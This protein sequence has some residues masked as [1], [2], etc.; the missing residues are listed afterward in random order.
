M[1]SVL[2][3][4]G[5][6]RSE[7]SVY[8]TL[9]KLGP[10]TAGKIAKHACISRVAVYDALRRLITDGLVSETLDKSRRILIAVHPKKI[11]LLLEDRQK[12][13]KRD[14]NTV[15]HMFALFN[16][17]SEHTETKVYA[18]F[19]GLKIFYEEFL[20]AAKD[21]WLVLGVPKRAELMGGFL[22]DLSQRRAKKMIKL[23]IIFNK[24]AKKLISVR[25]KQPLAQVRI[26]PD[27]YITPASIDI[28]PDRV[29]IAIYSTEPMVF[30]FTN[31][32]VADSFRQYFNLIWKKSKKV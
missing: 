5:Y 23:R 22:K 1:R 32:D 10:L 16:Q 30:T 31:K 13:I 2:N 3:N 18:G 12:Q 9:L 20:D 7:S 6:S 26:L 19:C 21:E 29:G 15:Q 8:V 17:S 24:D 11:Q 25:K 14:E 4:L 27:N 28:L